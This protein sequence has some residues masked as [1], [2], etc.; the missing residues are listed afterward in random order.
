MNFSPTSSFT[1][2]PFLCSRCHLFNFF[3][4]SNHNNLTCP[5]THQRHALEQIFEESAG[6]FLEIFAQRSHFVGHCI[7]ELQNWATSHGHVWRSSPPSGICKLCLSVALHE[8]LDIFFQGTPVRNYSPWQMGLSVEAILA[9]HV[10]PCC[11]SFR[12]IISSKVLVGL[13]LKRLTASGVT[14]SSCSWV[15]AN[16]VIRL[17]WI[18]RQRFH[19]Q[20]FSNQCGRSSQ[21]LS[22]VVCSHCQQVE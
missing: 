17:F 19:L 18:S 11:F 6:C 3:L 2:G 9:P 13:D 22:D 20:V 16:N 12:F 4:R 1:T 5:K 14:V 10:Q 15:G 21:R 8:S 7:C